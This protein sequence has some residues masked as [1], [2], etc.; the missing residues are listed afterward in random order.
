[1]HVGWRLLLVATP[2]GFPDPNLIIANIYLQVKG[3]RKPRLSIPFHVVA[4]TWCEHLCP[5]LLHQPT[6]RD[7]GML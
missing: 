6:V 3:H 4:W 1:M 2:L 7:A 5:C